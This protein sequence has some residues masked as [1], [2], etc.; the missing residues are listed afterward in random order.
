MIS[1]RP[2]LKEPAALVSALVSQLQ[3]QDVKKV[4]FY[5]HNNS[6]LFNIESPP[7]GQYN[8][9]SDFDVGNPKKSAITK[10]HL[11]SFGAPHNVYKKVYNPDCPNPVNVELLPGPGTYNDRTM[12][13]GTEGRKYRMQGRSLNMSGKYLISDKLLIMI[14][15]Y[16]PLEH[17]NKIEY[18]SSWSLWMWN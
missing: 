14:S 13:I 2:E 5:F 4:S 12:K 17:I 9:L 1:L 3:W 15:L 11:Y 10:G 7:P 8:L 6:N 16:R 18:S